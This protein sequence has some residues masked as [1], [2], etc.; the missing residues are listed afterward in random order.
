MPSAPGMPAGSASVAYAGPAD[1]IANGTVGM[2]NAG[3]STSAEQF[4]QGTACKM[5][6]T[7]LHVGVN[8][9]RINA[10]ARYFCICDGFEKL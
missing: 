1:D 4:N 10:E 9:L 3:S 8:Y 5:M 6:N 2:P 7:A